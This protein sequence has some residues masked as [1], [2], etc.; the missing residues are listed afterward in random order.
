MTDTQIISLLES[1]MNSRQ[2]RIQDLKSWLSNNINAPESEYKSM[3]ARLDE[4]TMVSVREDGFYSEL[5][6]KLKENAKN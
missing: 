1:R 5:I 6:T 4:L 2:T 3:Y